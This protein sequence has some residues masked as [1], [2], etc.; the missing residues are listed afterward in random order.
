MQLLLEV[1]VPGSIGAFLAHQLSPS[2]HSSYSGSSS[3]FIPGLILLSSLFNQQSLI[4]LFFALRHFCTAGRP[5]SGGGEL[6]SLSTLFQ[7]PNFPDEVSFSPCHFCRV[8]HFPA[9]GSQLPPGST[10]SLGP[11]LHFLA[12]LCGHIADP[13]PL[14]RSSIRHYCGVFLGDRLM[15]FYG[16]HHSPSLLGR[17]LSHPTLTLWIVLRLSF[18]IGW[19]PSTQTGMYKLWISFLL[20]K[21]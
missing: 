2:E 9:G 13:T 6:L 14:P 10:I 5:Y 18:H 11:F 15:L 12:K 8:G 3:N 7:G 17:W 4:T 19:S 16:L 20:G 1:L 21:I